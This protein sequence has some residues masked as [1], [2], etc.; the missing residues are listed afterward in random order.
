LVNG[1]LARL[2]WRVLA[3]DYR[4]MRARLCWR[5]QW[6]APELPAVADEIR[7]A[8]RERLRKA[9]P[10]IGIAI[11]HQGGGPDAECPLEPAP[12]RSRSEPQVTKTAKAS[13]T[14]RANKRKAKLR[15]K[16]RRQRARATA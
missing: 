15:A 7:K 6:V 4:L 11:R 10:V 13:K 9:F 2:F 12:T 16:H 14:I 8:D 5:T 3:P 1:S